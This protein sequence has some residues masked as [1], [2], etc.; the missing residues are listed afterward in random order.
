MLCDWGVKANM[1]LFAGN[2]VW[3]IS[4]CVRGVCV[5]ALYKSTFTYF[6]LLCKLCFVLK[7]VRST[8][9]DKLT[10]DFLHFENVVV[11]NVI[12]CTRWRE[13]GEQTRRLK[14]FHYIKWPDMKVPE[15]LSMLSFVGLVRS[16]VEDKKG[17]P[18]VVHCRYVDNCWYTDICVSSIPNSLKL[19]NLRHSHSLSGKCCLNQITCTYTKPVLFMS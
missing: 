19:R 16:Y 3:S 2:T 9:F 12:H 1:V 11:I 15:K 18:I 5:Y 17:H 13:Q 14:H 6:T 8:K 7:N 4:E 10:I